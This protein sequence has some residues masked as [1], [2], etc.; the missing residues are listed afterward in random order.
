MS[1]M[2]N[3][4]VL[5]QDTNELRIESVSL[6]DPGPTQVIVKVFSSGI[7]H[8]QLHQMHAPRE[9]P[10]LLGHEATGMVVKKGTDVG[11]VEEGDS[12]LMLSLIHI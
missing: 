2:S 5:P 6:P 1:S 9:T 3:V 12:V 4:A 11:H 8:S 10:I 7:C